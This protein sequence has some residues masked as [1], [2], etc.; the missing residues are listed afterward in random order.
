M[1]TL[2]AVLVGF[3]W[4]LSNP[5][6]KSG[7]EELN[8]KRGQLSANGRPL[9][10]VA[11]Y[12]RTPAFLVPQLVNICGSF[13][14]AILLSVGELSVVVPIA[15]ATALA[16]N[17]VVDLALGQQYDWGFLLTGLGLVAVGILL[18]TS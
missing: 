8:Q 11:L 15:N 10:G 4:G 6:I 5:F 9:E 13:G 17:T 12:L 2:S 7:S 16:V 18:C 1:Q 3:V 14:F